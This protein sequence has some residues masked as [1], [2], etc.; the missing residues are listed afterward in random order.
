MKYLLALIVLSLLAA[1][2]AC[3][4]NASHDANGRASSS[5][6]HAVVVGTV[7]DAATGE[8]VAN[9]DVE[10]PADQKTRSDARGRFEFKPLAVGTEGEI[11]ASTNDGRKARVTLRRLAPGRLEVVLQLT[12]R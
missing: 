9:A 1:F 5:T 3:G 6:T 7:V 11:T 4:S 10:G 12:K 2:T 8:A